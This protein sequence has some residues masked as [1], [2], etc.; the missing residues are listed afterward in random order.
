MNALMA[1]AKGLIVVGGGEEEQYEFIGEHRLRPIINV[2][3]YEDDV[4]TQIAERLLSGKE[5]ILQLQRDSKE[6]VRRHHDHISVA[7]QYLQLYSS[8]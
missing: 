2:Q 7:K 3:P 6:Y 8:L 5:N 1:M 4:Y